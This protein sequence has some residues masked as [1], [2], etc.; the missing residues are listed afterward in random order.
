MAPSP[1]A[2]PRRLWRNVHLVV[3]IGAALLL[4]PIGL[5]GSLLVWHDALDAVLHPGRYAVSAG[6]VSPPSEHVAA[7]RAALGA[8]FQPVVVRYPESAQAPVTVSA[9]DSVPERGT[10]P[11]LLTVYLDPPTAGVLGVADF[12]SS[13]IGVLHRFHEN[14]TIP[15]YNGRDIVGWAG[16]AMLIM[17]LTGLYLWWPRNHAWSAALRWQRGAGTASRL[18]HQFGFWICAPLAVLSLTGIYLGF[19]QQGRAVLSSVTAMSPQQRG[20]FGAPLLQQTRLTID[21]AL[22]AA[23]V[24]TPDARPAAIF[25]PTQQAQ[26]W[27]VQLRQ[28]DELITVMVDDRGGG[29]SR[30]SPQLAGDSVAAWIRWIHDGSRGGIVWQVIIFLCGIFPTVL[31]ITGVIIWLQRR[32]RRAATLRSAGGRAGEIPQ[33]GAAE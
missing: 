6:P 7:A 8:T 23:L 21:Q 26:T 32:V 17:A 24:S 29:A 5:S 20:G 13:F 12:R 1:A 10:R 16:V 9:R 15:E 11:R 27:R 22:H 4:I 19:P 18:H 33:L 31:A 25:L 2:R 14:L 30:A 3:G 28:A